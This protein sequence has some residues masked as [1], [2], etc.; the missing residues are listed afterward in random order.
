MHT[1]SGNW[2]LGFAF[3]LTTAFLWGFLPIALKILLDGMDPWTITWWRFAVSMAGLGAF[4]ALRGELP[5]R[6]YDRAG[7]V[8]LLLALLT[9]TSN[10]VLYL[11][12]LRY[13]TPSVAQV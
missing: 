2:R 4:L 8:L 1:G 12:A 13:T 5:L 11:V 6:G 3:S 9:L 7:I 10:Y